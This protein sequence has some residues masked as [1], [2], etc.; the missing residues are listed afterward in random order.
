M[1]FPPFFFDI[2]NTLWLAHRLADGVLAPGLAHRL[3]DGA[4]ASELVR[5]LVSNF[6]HLVV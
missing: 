5:R 1:R 3:P 4:L 2:N 6:I